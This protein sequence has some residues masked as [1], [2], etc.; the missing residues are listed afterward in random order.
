MK[1]CDQC[2]HFLKKNFQCKVFAYTYFEQIQNKKR[3]FRKDLPKIYY[4]SVEYV[5]AKPYLCGINALY[6]NARLK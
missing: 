6:F 2:I 1:Y 5:R 3:N 4:H